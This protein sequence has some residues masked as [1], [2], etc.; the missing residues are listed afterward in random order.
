MI[1]NLAY[2]YKLVVSKYQKQLLL[3]H[4]FA[5]NQTWNILLNES[6]K[7][8]EANKLRVEQSLE[9]IFLSSVDQDNLVKRVL[10][11]RNLKFN[12]KVVQQTRVNFNKTFKQTI[13]NIKSKSGDGMLKFKQSRNF[14]NQAIETTKEQYKILDLNDKWK[15]LRLFNESFKIR[16]TRDFPLN[17]E[18]SSLT[19]SFK[20]NHFYVSL[21]LSYES[22]LLS[23]CNKQ[24]IACKKK[25]SN[26]IKSI[27]MDINIDSID[28]GN[29]DFHKV[30]KIKDIKLNNLISKN[31][32]KI[33]RLQRKQARR[34][35]LAKKSKIKLGKNFKKTQDKINKIHTKN[36][37]I[38][39]FQLHKL[40]NEILLFLRENNLNHIVMEKLNVKEMTKSG[41]INKVIGKKNSIAMKRNILHISFHMLK[42][43]ITYKCAMNGVYVN[44]VDPKNTSKTCS[45]C[46]K[47]DKE[48]NLTKRIYNC[49][50][51]LSISRD[52]NACLNIL[53][54]R[55]ET[56]QLV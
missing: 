10:R 18:V 27:G 13:K 53:K 12:T 19:I 49:G 44:F 8:F 11:D 32:K 14:N 17:S 36:C 39:V 23:E 2:K 34:I 43:M 55:V 42:E 6:N 29:Q 35:I 22:N 3:N 15:I 24:S 47:I 26:D 1:I 48:L 37:N 38:K 9:P 41:K 56:T 52:Y 20:D 21:N 31:Q 45:A 25:I 30:F 50:C 46:G 33:K 7:Q 28:L 40:V 16:W 4:I 51:G 54:K 5:H